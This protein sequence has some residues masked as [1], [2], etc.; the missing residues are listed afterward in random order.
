MV[1]RVGQQAFRRV[2]GGDQQQ[3]PALEQRLE[4]P[5]DQHRI[6]DVVDVKLVETQHPAIAQQLIQRGRQR[7]RLL[8]MAEHALVQ[9]G[10]KTV[11][12]Q[13]LLLGKGDRLEKTVEQPAFATPDSSVEVEPR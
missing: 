6:A 7:I 3:D 12:V 8:A 10:E 2:V 9:A 13:A 11:E 5:R 1:K 4:Q